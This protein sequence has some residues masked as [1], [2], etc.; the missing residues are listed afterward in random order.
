MYLVSCC[1]ARHVNHQSTRPIVKKV[2]VVAL[3]FSIPASCVYI[4]IYTYSCRNYLEVHRYFSVRVEQ[5][6]HL[7]CKLSCQVLYGVSDCLG[8]LMN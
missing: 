1:K 8:I 5:T 6:L 3:A 4:C 7:L 2:P